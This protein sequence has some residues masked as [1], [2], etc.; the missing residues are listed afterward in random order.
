M[1]TGIVGVI[2]ATIL[3]ASSCSDGGSSS[4]SHASASLV[5]NTNI[6][7]GSECEFG[8]IRVESGI[9]NNNNGVLDAGEIDSTEYVCNGYCPTLP[10]VVATSPTDDTGD[11]SVSAAINAVFNRDLDPDSINGI[12]YSISQGG[13]KIPGA[14]SYNDK[15]A[16]FTPASLLMPFTEYT[17]SV[18]TGIADAEG[19][20]LI[21]A[22][23]WTFTTGAAEP[24]VAAPSVGSNTPSNLASDVA[25]STTITAVFDEAMA[26]GT[27]NQTT[28][29]VV[30]GDSTA[31]V[32]NVTYNGYT[33]TFA[34]ST[35]LSYATQYI[36]TIDGGNG[37]AADLSGNEMAASHSWNFTT[38]SRIWG[39]PA[40][41]E[42]ITG[43]HNFD[44]KVGLDD[45]G[46]AWVAWLYDNTGVGWTDQWINEYSSSVWQ[47]AAEQD[48]GLFDSHGIVM[49]S[50]GVTMT[51]ANRDGVNNNERNCDPQGACFSVSA[52]SG[53]YAGGE[54]DVEINDNG[55]VSSV[56]WESDLIY[57]KWF[58]V[59][60]QNFPVGSQIH[61]AFPGRRPATAIDNNGWALFAYWETTNNKL[62]YYY[63]DG[64]W[65]FTTALAYNGAVDNYDYPELKMDAAGN[66]YLVFQGDIG[67]TGIVSLYGMGYD[68]TLDSWES[69]QAIDNLSTSVLAAAMDMDSSGAMLA[70]W[71]QDDG[72]A[73]SVFAS[74]YTV[75]TGWEAPEQ[76][77]TL[78]FIAQTPVVKV[79]QSG[80]GY[81]VW[82]QDDGAGTDN[83]Y[84]VRY[85]VSTS[86]WSLPSIVNDIG[87]NAR[88]PNIEVNQPG[89]AIA[90][91]AQ[92]DST[93]SNYYSIYA[94]ALE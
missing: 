11:I 68:P 77:D 16:I 40:K 6:L 69:P 84:V 51:L 7:S 85:D 33:V 78:D 8:G 39:S 90:V 22:Y 4:S 86:T 10:S 37:G 50:H 34:P 76:I 94:A 83:I 45:S 61:G 93:D 62:A 60:G 36:V 42:S 13:S 18:T 57:A 87:G 9:D 73:N 65:D 47:T 28:V 29:H 71:I 74:K 81:A 20:A 43:D 23:S 88:E 35:P 32:G 70:I 44:P 91:W 41:I 30:D 59:P 48:T 92:Q 15:I 17:A 89:D 75:G 38:Q 5:K 25:L 27:I 53:L 79:D 72:I 55:V 54:W 19:N 64:A 56:S 67:S 49:N 24:D 12:T 58:D 14:I 3:M 31:L 82:A 21:Q 63:Y 1:K 26:P 80:N 2:L 66:G 52:A 46:N